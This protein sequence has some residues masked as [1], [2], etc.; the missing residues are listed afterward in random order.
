MTTYFH[1]KNQKKLLNQFRDLALRTDKRTETNSLD[2]SP[3]TS[4]QKHA[5]KLAKW[6]RDIQV[7]HLKWKFCLCRSIDLWNDNLGG[8]ATFYEGHNI[9]ALIWSVHFGL[10]EV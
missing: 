7:Q 3:S 10:F 9:I 6:R 4:V 5:T 2:I 1:A 8:Q